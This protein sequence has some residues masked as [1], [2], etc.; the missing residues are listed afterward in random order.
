MDGLADEKKKMLG[1][2]TTLPHSLPDVKKTK[3]EPLDRYS[4]TGLDAVDILVFPIFMKYERTILL[5]FLARVVC[6]RD[7]TLKLILPV[8]I[9]PVRSSSVISTPPMT[10]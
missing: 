3:Q 10:P 4:T 2:V 9:S 8:W 7:L 6:L 1:N 5:I